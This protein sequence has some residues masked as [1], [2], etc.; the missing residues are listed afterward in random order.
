MVEFK[1][2]QFTKIN[3]ANSPLK[4][5]EDMSSVIPIVVKCINN[6]RPQ[7]DMFYK[8]CCI[9]PGSVLILR[10]LF[11]TDD[12]YKIFVTQFGEVLLPEDKELKIYKNGIWESSIDSRT[13]SIP[14][15]AILETCIV[16]MIA[17]CGSDQL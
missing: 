4:N 8:Y 5:N 7:M 16:E 15:K 14:V 12:P 3:E 1:D 9:V 11:G 17:A 10:K 13:T 2:D 6:M